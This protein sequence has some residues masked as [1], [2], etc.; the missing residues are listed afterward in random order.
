MK[1]DMDIIRLL[2]L[3]LETDEKQE[4]LEKYSQKEILYNM[5]QM[6]DAGLAIGDVVRGGDNEPIGGGLD[7]LTWAGHDFLDAA[8][9]DTLWK[10]AKQHVIK[11]GASFTFE[12]VK[13]W[14][15]LEIK[16]RIG[17]G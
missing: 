16:N 2:M 1:R 10:K 13:E 9:D 3:E 4:A 8:R 15:K 14:L 12:L 11:P 7:Q 6:I 5:S 17:L